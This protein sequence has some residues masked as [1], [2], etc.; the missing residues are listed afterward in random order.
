MRNKLSLIIL[1][2]LFSSAVL[3]GDGEY[4]VFRIPKE[5][6]KNANAVI[7]LQEQYT[8][9]LKEDKLF[10]REHYVITILNEEGDRFSGMFEYY[11][12]FRDIK[13]VDGTLYDAMGM[14]IKSLKNKDIEDGS[15]SSGNNLADDSRYKK[16]NF[17]HRV[18]PYTIEYTIESVKKETMFFSSWVPV[19]SELIAVQKSNFVVDVPVGYLLRY[20]PFNYTREPVIKE[21][22]GRK[23]YNWSLENYEA[24][25]R[26][27]A[28]PSWKQITPAVLFAPSDFVIEDFKGTMTDWKEL[29]KF[30]LSLN[31]G[32]D[33]LPAEMKAKVA[34]LTRGV[35][36]NE[37]KVVRLYQFLQSNTRYISIQLGIGGWRPLEASFVAGK[38]YGDCKA[39]SNYMYALLKEA[40]IKSHYTLI[41]AGQGEDDLELDFPSRQFNH[42]IICV[43]MEKDSLWLECTSQTQSPGYMG[44]FTG[45]RH[46]LLITE[47]GGKVTA[48]P[49][50]G[51]NDN[52]QVRQI[53]AQ[54]TEDGR[55]QVR[56]HTIYGCMQQDDLQMLINSLSKDKVKEVLQEKLDFATYE[57]DRFNYKEHKSKRPSVEEELDISVSN[58]ATITGKRLF[59]VPNIMTRHGRRLTQ[60][61][62]RKYPLELDV[63]YRDTD[64]VEIVIPAGYTA[65]SVPT[66]VVLETRFGKYRSTVKI[67]GNRILYSRTMEHFAGN[68]AAKEYAD[69]VKFYDAMYK[70]DRARLVLVKSESTPKS[71]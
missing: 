55:L 30:Q 38:L 25:K 32:R 37:E 42:A 48:T 29:G 45:N 15:G 70:A 22:G 44:G 10:T 1:S 40:G 68:F 56:A 62:E 17:Y 59:I 20:K 6:L 47:E 24:V 19:W 65:E 18:Y 23:V 7:R 71:F 4:A 50:Y 43:P 21:A 52:T 2:C 12:K 57:V 35:A 3:A 53:K 28:A 61:E 58:Y 16:H 8:E 5:L 26:E 64:S 66:D 31:K 67:D 13:S 46:A 39:L 34:E 69:L 51:I 27:F 60:Q 63:E 14:K 49:R 9:L 41:K 36:S 54:L 33:Q 11:D